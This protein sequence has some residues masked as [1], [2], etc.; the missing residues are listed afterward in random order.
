ML[1]TNNQGAGLASAQN[2]ARSMSRIESD[3]ENLRNMTSRVEMITERIVRHARS[4][5]YFEPPGNKDQV[6]G[7]TPVITTLADALQV[8]DRALDHASG[9]LNVFD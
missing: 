8:L 5:G 2:S 7:P 1:N 4:L 9:S 3:V 6:A